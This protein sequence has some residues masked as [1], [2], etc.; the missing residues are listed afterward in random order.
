MKT[1]T[2]NKG[3]A[4]KTSIKAGGLA[5]NHNRSALKVRSS[6]KAGGIWVGNH[7]RALAVVR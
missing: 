2:K 5:M 7:N 6:V 3:L 1:S 4:I